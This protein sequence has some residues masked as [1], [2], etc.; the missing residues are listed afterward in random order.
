MKLILI[1]N[2][3]D[4]KL[5]DTAYSQCYRHQF[6]AL[7][8]SFEEVVHVTDKCD[9][10]DIE[11]DVIIFY[12]VHSSHQI[13][14]EGIEKHPAIKY[15]YFN[16]PHQKHTEGYYHEGLDSNNQYILSARVIKLSAE[17]RTKRALKR[18]VNYI[19]CPFTEPYYNYIAPY[20]DEPE[21][22]RVWF[23]VSPSIEIY[24][25]RHRLLKDRKNAVLG[26]GAEKESKKFVEGKGYGTRTW[27]FRQYYIDFVPHCVDT[28]GKVSPTPEANDY[29]NFLSRYAGALALTDDHIV[30]KYSE[31]P[32]AGCVCFASEHEDYK[33]MGF[34]DGENCIFVTK[35][36]L[37]DKVLDFKGHVEDYQGLA[38]KGR[39]LIENKWTAEKFGEFIREH[40]NDTST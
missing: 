26:N 11:G 27:A 40:C 3:D 2:K 35:E 5:A 37:K 7:Q 38:D 14:L 22:M 12:D 34:K 15:E 6:L 36:N 23:P 16:D 24:T 21:K 30:P 10:L 8:K 9:I 39:E 29:P 25:K 19:I 4:R 28:R 31:I 17:E 32:L 18:G 13:D 33:L 20:L 1:Y